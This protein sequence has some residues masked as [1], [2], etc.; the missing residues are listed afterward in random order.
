M[1]VFINPTDVY[2]FVGIQSFNYSS[3]I[4]LMTLE[5]DHK[6]FFILIIFLNY[7]KKEICDCI[8]LSKIIFN[9]NL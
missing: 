4:F 5:L 9:K 2:S 6:L 7:V 8:M 3:C 1:H